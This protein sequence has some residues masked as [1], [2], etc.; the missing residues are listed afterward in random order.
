[1]TEDKKGIEQALG[2][3]AKNLCA[4][5]TELS[6]LTNLKILE[7]A[8]SQNPLQKKEA[9]EMILGIFGKEGEVRAKAVLG[10]SIHKE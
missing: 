3:I 5:R 9:I 1:M 7:I 10:L 2:N 6:I 8:N 4:L